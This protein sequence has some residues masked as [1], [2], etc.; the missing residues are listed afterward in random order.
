MD[1]NIL[2]VLPKGKEEN[3]MENEPLKAKKS[4]KMDTLAKEAKD[5]LDNFRT[6]LLT[7]TFGPSKKM[8][9]EPKYGLLAKNW[10]GVEEETKLSRKLYSTVIKF[11]LG[12]KKFDTKFEQK[13]GRDFKTKIKSLLAYQGY[14]LEHVI[15]PNFDCVFLERCPTDWLRYYK[16][17]NRIED[18]FMESED[19]MAR[20]LI[21]DMNRSEEIEE[22]VMKNFKVDMKEGFDVLIILFEVGLITSFKQVTAIIDPNQLLEAVKV[23]IS[24]IPDVDQCQ[25]PLGPLDTSIEAQLAHKEKEIVN[26]IRFGY[27]FHLD[28]IKLVMRVFLQ[29]L[30]VISDEAYL[31]GEEDKYLFSCAKRFEYVRSFLHI[32]QENRCH[33][34]VQ[35]DPQVREII[36][37]VMVCIFTYRFDPIS[38]SIL[39]L[40]R[41][42]NQYIAAYQNY[43]VRQEADTLRTKLEEIANQILE[44]YFSVSEFGKSHDLQRKIEYLLME[45]ELKCLK[46]MDFKIFFGLNGSGYI[47]LTLIHLL[48]SNYEDQG[49]KC[50]VRECLRILSVACSENHIVGLQLL[51]ERPLFILKRLMKLDSVGTC[52]VLYSMISEGSFLIEQNFIVIEKILQIMQI[53]WQYFI[54]K[55]AKKPSV[56]KP[57]EIISP[58]QIYTDLKP[59]ELASLAFMCVILR[60]IIKNCLDENTKRMIQIRIQVWFTP[61]Y[62]T[63]TLNVCLDYLRDVGEQHMD[64]KQHLAREQLKNLSPHASPIFVNKSDAEIVALFQ[65]EAISKEVSKLQSNMVEWKDSQCLQLKVEAVYFVLS[66]FNEASR[67][68]T[69]LSIQKHLGG[70]V[71]WRMEFGLYNFIHLH[72][73]PIASYLFTE[74]VVLYC[75]SFVHQPSPFELSQMNIADGPV[76]IEFCEKQK[77]VYAEV[78][79]MPDFFEYLFDKE[80]VLNEPQSLEV[81][82]AI[83]VYLITQILVGTNFDLYIKDYQKAAMNYVFRGYLRTIYKFLKGYSMRLKSPTYKKEDFAKLY[84]IIDKICT[85]ISDKRDLI[86]KIADLSEKSC[87]RLKKER[88]LNIV[89]ADWNHGVAVKPSVPNEFGRYQKF[90]ENI[91]KAIEFIFD[92]NAVRNEEI[93]KYRAN[94]TSSPYI[95]TVLDFSDDLGS[96]NLSKFTQVRKEKSQYVRILE[97]AVE[98]GKNENQMPVLDKNTSEQ[99]FMFVKLNFQKKYLALSKTYVKQKKL[100]VENIS[101][102]K[103]FD[104]LNEGNDTGKDIFYVTLLEWII[105]IF[106]HHMTKKKDPSELMPEPEPIHYAFCFDE[107]LF[108]FL[109]ILDNLFLLKPDLKNFNFRRMCEPELIVNNPNAEDQK[110]GKAQEAQLHVDPWFNKNHGMYF[111][112]YLIKN[113]LH[114]QNVL[115]N[116]I[117]ESRSSQYFQFYMMICCCL[118]QI[119]EGKDVEFKTKIGQLEMKIHGEVSEEWDKYH[120]FLNK[121][122]KSLYFYRDSELDKLKREEFVWYNIISLDLLSEFLRGP[123]RRNQNLT[124][125][126]DSFP[127]M[128]KTLQALQEDPNSLIFDMQRSLVHFMSALIEQND[129]KGGRGEELKTA[130]RPQDVHILIYRYTSFLY[131]NKSIWKNVKGLNPTGLHKTPEEEKEVKWRRLLDL[132]K[133]NKK[134]ADHPALEIATNLYFLMKNVAQ[135]NEPNPFKRFLESKNKEVKMTMEQNTGF[136]LDFTHD[137]LRD[138]NVRENESIETVDQRRK[139]NDKIKRNELSYFHFIEKTSSSVEILTTKVNEKSQSLEIYFQIPPKC[140]YLSDSSRE[141]F[142]G[143]CS[144]K[145]SSTKLIDLMEY[146]EHASVLIDNVSWLHEWNVTIAFI[147]TDTAF[148]FYQKFLWVLGFLQNVLIIFGS[149]F[150]QELDMSITSNVFASIINWVMIFVSFFGLLLWFSFKY[151]EAY[152]TNTLRQRASFNQRSH[153]LLHWLRTA[154]FHSIIERHTPMT[155]LVH[156]VLCIVFFK[157]IWIVFI[158]LYTI[159]FLSRT[160]QYV[161]QSI[162]AHYDQLLYTFILVLF[163]IYSFAFLIGGYFS[164]T[165]K[166]SGTATNIRECSRLSS[167]LFYVL[168][169]GV[170]IGGGIGES[171]RVLDHRTHDYASAKLI[172]NLAFFIFIN[173]ISLNIVF[174]IIIDTFAELRDEALDRGIMC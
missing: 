160:V 104:W 6:D 96:I 22:G 144:L 118:G 87:I 137:F 39:L 16:F 148:I 13:I 101:G 125:D 94:S 63:P 146:I 135:F 93:L 157:Y 110:R 55:L 111:I 92:E 5:L 18:D 168:D 8:P 10:I 83:E 158:H 31:R 109:V 32:V 132:Y 150:N 70:I 12:L 141:E 67:N 14:G 133:H 149:E 66:L 163:A 61:E 156:L 43:V 47:L 42:H 153:R 98:K 131:Q 173:L 37:K 35:K 64:R 145:D 54:E 46:T 65:P 1:F 105:K 73:H 20:S 106:S 33:V 49:V 77:A 79:E 2:K 71:Y 86:V 119:V 17:N 26:E 128:F 11:N 142:L 53:P 164:D 112:Y 170:R 123:S 124:V 9:E 154:V 95:N 34:V 134:F 152:R 50:L 30:I 78:L 56:K 140:L 44:S 121:I 90:I 172:L 68:F 85:T 143:R 82:R 151:K 165:F 89:E 51:K 59:L 48:T 99:F 27:Q 4:E 45:I 23:H 171:M 58:D 52:L 159:F 38:K 62:E 91:L 19:P 57:S 161:I 69:D 116:E 138:S 41:E 76:M 126:K 108:A 40:S 120:G 162:T 155:F 122:Y 147:T 75:N 29:I 117:F 114:L 88:W 127:K 36:N 28:Q 74:V 102:S 130:V 167:C 113:I 84:K 129:G 139:L 60:K 3:E 21:R 100:S 166:S 97:F 81:I 15:N 169:L 174:G 115:R 25:I 103:L 24:K 107:K 7:T 72:K 136:D 80:P